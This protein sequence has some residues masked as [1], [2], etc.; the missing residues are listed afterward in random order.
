[1]E[2]RFSRPGGR[3][4]RLSVCVSR[5]IPSEARAPGDADAAGDGTTQ[6]L[7]QTPRRW[8]AEFYSVL[9]RFILSDPHGHPGQGIRLGSKSAHT[10]PL[11]GFLAQTE[12]LRVAA[13]PGF[14][15]SS[16]R[17]LDSDAAWK[18]GGGGM[19]ASEHLLC[20]HS[21]AGG[22]S[23]HSTQ[24]LSYFEIPLSARAEFSTEI[25]TLEG[26]LL[27]HGFVRI[28]N[29][30]VKPQPDHTWSVVTE[31]QSCPGGSPTPDLSLLSSHSGC[32]GD[33]RGEGHLR[34]ARAQT[35]WGHGPPILVPCC[36]VV[37]ALGHFS[38][39]S[40]SAVL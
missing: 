33:P 30:V 36:R 19:R 14:P 39:N 26:L 18:A 32:G 23:I 8:G 16:V 37:Q 12:V 29:Y 34:L 6:S 24:T 11:P 40:T 25:T 4:G 35:W 2:I 1:M 13:P 3:R 20:L 21:I 27:G 17:V 7:A 31:P 10:P 28:I 9:N 22:S 38:L 15:S 5:Q